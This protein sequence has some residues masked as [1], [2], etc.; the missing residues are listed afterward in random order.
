MASFDAP[1]SKIVLRSVQIASAASGSGV[2]AT[3]GLTAYVV[4]DP[5]VAPP[6]K[7]ASDSRRRVSMPKVSRPVIYTALAAVA[8]YA[9]RS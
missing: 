7:P 2:T 3:L 4:S 6:V 9:R 8:A 1:H 5:A